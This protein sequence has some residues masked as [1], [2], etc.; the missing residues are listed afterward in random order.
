MR[1]LGAFL[2]ACCAWA[3][4]AKTESHI[5]AAGQA[6]REGNEAMRAQDWQRAEQSYLR[7]IDI[8]PTFLEA[9]RA[10][11]EL[12]SRTSRPMDLGAVLTRLLQIEPDSLPERLRL[13]QLLINSSEWN[14]AL[15]Q[16]SLALRMA[17]HN[18]D[19]LYWFGYAAM[20]TDMKDRAADALARGAA[21][22]PAD[23]RFAELL[24]QLK[25][26]GVPASRP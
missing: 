18:A 23:R 7:A 15:A 21:E 6:L 19:C 17:P 3:G 11:E 1:I 26:A 14:R 12:Y 22:F 4:T 9:Y 20:H 13:A 16:L 2:L 24:R 5:Q 10:L 8:E 25:P